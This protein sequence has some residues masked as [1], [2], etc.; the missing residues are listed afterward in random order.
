M[1]DLSIVFYSCYKPTYSW[2]HHL[3]ETISSWYPLD[4]KHGC[5]ITSFDPH[6]Q[7]RGVMDSWDAANPDRRVLNGPEFSSCLNHNQN[8]TVHTTDRTPN[9]FICFLLPSDLFFMPS[10][11]KF[12][13]VVL[14][15]ISLDVVL[16]PF[17]HGRHTA[18]AAADDTDLQGWKVIPQL[19]SKLHLWRAIAGH[20][21]PLLAIGSWMHHIWSTHQSK[22]SHFGPCFPLQ[23]HQIWSGLLWSRCPE[24]WGSPLRPS[25]PNEAS[26]NHRHMRSALLQFFQI[27]IF[28][29]AEWLSFSHQTWQEIHQTN[30]GQ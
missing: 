9:Y 6:W 16:C 28:L 19:C 25:C 14:I 5:E 17:G 11:D 1:V 21:W 2:E 15:K 23:S 20:G 26:T 29:A 3:R 30:A 22:I 13:D 8:H 27:S 7:V 12:R 18:F 4:I 24:P 10:A